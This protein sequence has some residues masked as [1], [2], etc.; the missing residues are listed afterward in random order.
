[1][2]SDAT[3]RLARRT[4]LVTGAGSPAGRAI[5][6]RFA[7]EGAWIVA[8]DGDVEAA[9]ATAEAARAAGAP[10]IGLKTAAL[11]PTITETI[12]T[13]ALQRMWQIDILVNNTTTLGDGSDAGAI[14]WAA[15]MA[16]NLEASFRF[17]RAVLPQMQARRTGSIITVA[18]CWGDSGDPAEA[19]ARDTSEAAVAKLTSRLVEDHG[20]E[21]LRAHA[22]CPTAGSHDPA[23]V[24]GND[25]NGASIPVD[26][27]APSE[28]VAEW[29]TQLAATQR[30]ASG[31]ARAAVA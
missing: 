7:R 3:Q 13:T 27:D 29:A 12:V 10:A 31:A 24:T 15:T 26:W 16:I 30:P 17:A 4:A 20:H 6:E 9:E 11:D 21:G 22:L 1:M 19:L 8:V 23:D 18:W 14:D 2:K 28:R 25:D 5:C